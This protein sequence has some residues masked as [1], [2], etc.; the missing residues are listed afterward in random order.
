VARTQEHLAELLKLPAEERAKAAR[1]LLDSLDEGA[2]A[3][4]EQ[5]HLDALSRRMKALE[6]G[7]VQLIDGAEA[8]ARVLARLRSVRGP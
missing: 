6:E 1:T 4:V 2:D 5:A 3:D 7:R 8:R